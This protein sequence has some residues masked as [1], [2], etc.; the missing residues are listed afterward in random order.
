MD[1]L[2]AGEP[3]LALGNGMATGHFESS[4]EVFELHIASAAIA[5]LARSVGL[6]HQPPQSVCHVCDES[7]LR[8]IR[9][10]EC[11]SPACAEPAQHFGVVAI[12]TRHGRRL[13]LSACNR[14]ASRRLGHW[15]HASLRACECEWRLP[16]GSGWQGNR[17]SVTF[18]YRNHCAWYNCNNDEHEQK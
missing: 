8:V 17:K 9:G 7:R 10:F 1:L 13:P 2:S 3:F 14:K 6:L 11:V 5:E 4:L 18:P 15:R 16:H 12:C